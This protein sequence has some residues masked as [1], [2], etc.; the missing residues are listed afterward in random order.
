MQP[1]WKTLVETHPGLHDK[2]PTEYRTIDHKI[3]SNS[4]SSAR[5]LR[6]FSISHIVLVDMEEHAILPELQLQI[7]SS[8]TTYVTRYGRVP[9][10][11]IHFDL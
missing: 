2:L 1:Y 7:K 5:S 3:V 8:T 9:V 11:T 6:G 10:D 4:K